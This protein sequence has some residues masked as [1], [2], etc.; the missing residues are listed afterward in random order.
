MWGGAISS[1]GVD[2]MDS[3]DGVD[4]VDEMFPRLDGGGF[5]VSGWGVIWGLVSW[6]FREF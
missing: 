6:C 1:K 2:G 4:R 5:L 3:M